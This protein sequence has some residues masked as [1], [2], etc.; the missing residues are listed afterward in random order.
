MRPS[1]AQCTPQECLGFT[2]ALFAFVDVTPKTILSVL[3]SCVELWSSKNLNSALEER[4]L[5]AALPHL[6]CQASA[7]VAPPGLKAD[8]M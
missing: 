7:R 3:T 6:S 8:E 4:R 2:L 1:V 5:S